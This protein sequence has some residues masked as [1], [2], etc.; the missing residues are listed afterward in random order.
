MPG[1]AAGAAVQVPVPLHY[2]CLL[3]LL[4]CLLA[5]WLL[6][7]AYLLRAFACPLTVLGLPGDSSLS[8]DLAVSWLSLAGTSCLPSGCM[9][10]ACCMPSEGVLHAF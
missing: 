9:L 2:N 4:I 5:A 6:L 1:P 7:I 3:N 8:A 10:L